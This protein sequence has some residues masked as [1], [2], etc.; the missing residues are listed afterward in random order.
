MTDTYKI[1][2]DGAEVARVSG[3]GITCAKRQRDRWSDAFEDDPKLLRIV[4]EGKTILVF[5]VSAAENVVV[6]KVSE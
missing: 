5:Y 2:V 3:E 4:R 6:E 1:S